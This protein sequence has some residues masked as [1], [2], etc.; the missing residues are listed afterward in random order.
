MSVRRGIPDA[1]LDA[2]ALLLLS[3]RWPEVSPP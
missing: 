3:V 1:A 2:A